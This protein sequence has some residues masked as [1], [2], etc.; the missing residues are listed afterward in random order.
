MKL[1]LLTEDTGMVSR[2]RAALRGMQDDG[3]SAHVWWNDEQQLAFISVGDWADNLRWVKAI[4]PIV[5]KDNIETTFEG[6]PD[7]AEPGWVVVRDT[8]RIR[9]SFRPMTPERRAEIGLTEGVVSAARGDILNV[10]NDIAGNV[11]RAAQAIFGDRELVGVVKFAKPQ[12]EYTNAEGDPAIVTLRIGG[13]SPET[14]SITVFGD[15]DG[16]IKLEMSER[17]ARL[18]R[19]G[20]HETASSV[21]EVSEQLGEVVAAIKQGLRANVNNPNRAQAGGYRQ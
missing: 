14:M 15:G 11:A 13:G 21:D 19:M 3:D 1:R 9:D 12:V 10:V 6:G 7:G 2:L 18:L 5:G 4:E 17:L 20:R 8:Q 16:E